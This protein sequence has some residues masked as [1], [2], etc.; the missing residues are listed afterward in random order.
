ML[1]ISSHNGEHFRED[2]F[3]KSFQHL[4]MLGYD[5]ID[6]QA[7]ATDPRE[8]T[9]KWDEKRFEEFCLAEKTAARQIGIEIVQTHSVW[10]YDDTKPELEQIIFDAKVK[11]LKG[12]ALVGAKYVVMHPVMPFGWKKSPHHAED[13]QANIDYLNRLLPYAKEYGVKIALE[14]MPC[15]YAPCGPI[16]ELIACIDGVDS[17]YVV[18]CL[19]TGHSLVVGTQPADAVHMLADRLHC[20]HI[21]DND[22]VDDLHWMPYFGKTNWDDFALALR[23][24]GYQGIMNLETVP[25]H[26]LPEELYAEADRWLKKAICHLARKAD[27]RE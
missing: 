24:I 5:A 16:E 25:S 22:G 3:Q 23:Q 10:P 19:D 15:Q 18:A 7:F 20:L 4:K 21:H 2:G 27:N 12:S 9:Y 8:G 14:N 1:K 17:E 11:S 13:V 26:N 6:Y